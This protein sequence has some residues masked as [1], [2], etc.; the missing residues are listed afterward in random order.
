[1][2]ILSAL[3]DVFI[4]PLKVIEDTIDYMDGSER[5]PSRTRKQIERIENDLGMGDK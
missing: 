3:F 2:R 5:K 4:L 1:M